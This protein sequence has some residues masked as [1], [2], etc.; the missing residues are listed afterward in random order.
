[1][2]PA[3]MVD[4]LVQRVGNEKFGATSEVRRYLQY[5]PLYQ[6]AYMLGGLQLCPCR[7][8]LSVRAG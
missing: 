2:G 6:A 3:E 1:M 8:K 4:F 7:K 5:S